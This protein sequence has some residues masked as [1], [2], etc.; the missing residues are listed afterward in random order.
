MLVD[1]P[2]MTLFISV[3]IA[4]TILLYHSYMIWF[5]PEK[6]SNALKNGVKGWWP[7]SDFYRRWFASKTFLWLFRIIYSI[8]LLALLLF[9]SILFLG[10]TGVFP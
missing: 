1:A 3:S 7:F 2:S 8:V 6:Y 5:F 9:L 10:I 4:V